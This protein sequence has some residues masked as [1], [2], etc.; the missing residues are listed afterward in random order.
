M[1]IEPEQFTAPLPGA[2]KD[3]QS[4]TSDWTVLQDL[5]DGVGLIEVRNVIRDSGHLTEVLRRDWFGADVEIDQVFQITLSPHG[6]S[7]WHVHL[8]TTDRLFVNAGQV[9]IVLYDARPE[10]PTHGQVNEFRLGE[11]RPGLVIVP[12][13]VWHGIKNLD[14][15]ESRVLNLVDV[16]YTYEDPDHWRLP[17]DTEQIPYSF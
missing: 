11:R 6:V 4:V 13:G 9:K 10:S 12:P 2:T 15:T 7:A 16:A 8:D 3:E 14:Q 17:A 5:I 1:S